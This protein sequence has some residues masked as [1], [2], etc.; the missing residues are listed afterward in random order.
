[1][2]CESGG[3]SASAEVVSSKD[4]R[5]DLK[6][7]PELYIESYSSFY[8]S[9]PSLPITFTFNA[10]HRR[11]ILPKLKLP[12]Y[13][14]T[15]FSGYKY[16]LKSLSS[17]KPSFMQ[18]LRTTLWATRS[19]LL[20]SYSPRSHNSALIIYRCIDGLGCQTDLRDWHYRSV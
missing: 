10:L 17:R 8:S 19:R 2:R 5:I 7:T 13:Q 9:S 15:S 20:H 12:L 6:S 16:L 4:K 14:F 11:F 18:I 1:M 3:T